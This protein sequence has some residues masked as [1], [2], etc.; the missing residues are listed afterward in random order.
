MIH[1]TFVRIVRHMQHKKGIAFLLKIY[2]GFFSLSFPN[3]KQSLEIYVFF[4]T[5]FKKTNHVFNG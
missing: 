1:N 5:K 2:S 4:E 3:N